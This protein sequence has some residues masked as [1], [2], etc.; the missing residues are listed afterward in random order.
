MKLLH[1]LK[2][3]HQVVVLRHLVGATLEFIPRGEGLILPQC[4]L[5]EVAVGDGEAH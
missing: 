1:G 5:E 2:I 3:H 4:P